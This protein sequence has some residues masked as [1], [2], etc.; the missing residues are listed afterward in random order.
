MGTLHTKATATQK[1]RIIDYMRRYGSITALDAFIDIGCE[2]LAAR[3][4]DL[5]KDGYKITS[6]TEKRFNRYGD[7]VHYSR[8]FL[9]SEASE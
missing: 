1:T 3:I 4:S 2:R 8:Y 6:K 9:E 7:K 5:K